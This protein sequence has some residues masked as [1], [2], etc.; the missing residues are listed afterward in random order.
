MALEINGAQAPKAKEFVP[1][2]IGVIYEENSLIGSVQDDRY[3][4]Y[5]RIL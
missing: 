4:L 5:Q 1:T 2:Q 3:P